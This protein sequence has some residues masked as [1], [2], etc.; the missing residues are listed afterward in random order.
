[1]ASLKP[2]RTHVTGD[3]AGIYGAML[4]TKQP[5]VW[6]VGCRMLTIEEHGPQNIQRKRVNN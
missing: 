6:L 2:C 4:L 1:M 3:S 5:W